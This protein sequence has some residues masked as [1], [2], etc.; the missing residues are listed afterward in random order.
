MGI[1]GL[2]GV[3]SSTRTLFEQRLTADCREIGPV[4]IRDFPQ[5]AP[6]DFD[7]EAKRGPEVEGSATREVQDVHNTNTRCAI[8]VTL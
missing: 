8:A 3:E 2:G 7:Q 1:V 6:L 5:S 4:I